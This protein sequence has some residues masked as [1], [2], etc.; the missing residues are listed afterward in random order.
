MNDI[1]FFILLYSE[2]KE[3]LELILKNKINGTS[4][5]HFFDTNININFFEQNKKKGKGAIPFSSY[6]SFLNFYIEKGQVIVDIEIIRYQDTFFD[7]IEKVLFH[8]DYSITEYNEKG[9]KESQYRKFRNDNYS[10]ILIGKEN[11]FDEKGTVI[12]TI[13]NDFP[14]SF[15]EL[16]DQLW[17]KYQIDIHRDFRDKKKN[18]RCGINLSKN[19]EDEQPF[20]VIQYYYW[21]DNLTNQ[22]SVIENNTLLKID[23]I[24]GQ[25]VFH[26]PMLPE[27]E[28]MYFPKPALP[29]KKQK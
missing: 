13:D 8:R 6:K 22:S 3:D 11:I 10:P 4:F 15:E 9:I 17:G 20:W 2:Y 18:Q 25:E 7:K 5:Y 26:R 23:G 16:A 21:T 28:A 1:D 19:Y 24:T 12:E 27:D 14:F 29:T